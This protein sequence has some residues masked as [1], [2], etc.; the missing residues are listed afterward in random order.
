[1]KTL[2]SKSK[3]AGEKSSSDFYYKDFC[4][5][6]GSKNLEPYLDL[7]E[8]PLVNNYGNDKKYELKV[9][10]CKDCYFSQLGIV[11]DPD[12]LFSHYYFQSSVSKLMSKHFEDLAYKLKDRF[13]LDKSSFCVDVASNDGI[14]LRAWKKIGVMFLGVDPAKN[15]AERANREGLDT[16]AEYWQNVNLGKK[17]DVITAANVFA[18]TDDVDG[19]LKSTSKNLKD[20]GVFVLEFPHGQE[21]ILKREFDTIYHEHLSYILLNPLV[22]LLE[23]Y[24]LQVIDVEKLDVH[25]GSLRVYVAKSNSKYEVTDWVKKILEEEKR[26][27]LLDINNYYRFAQE[28]ENKRK[29]LIGTISKIKKEGLIVGYA[30]SAKGNVLINYCGFSSKDIKYIIDDNEDKQ[31]NLIPGTD[32]P[33]V[34][35]SLLDKDKPKYLFILSPNIKEDIINKTHDFKKSGGRYIWAMPDIETI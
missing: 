29:E 7:G 17:A 28:V 35:R 13:D 25:G 19:F 10:L 16:I 15:L 31:G 11:V 18:H 23:K 26:N 30:A 14:M 4:R 32:I 3:E 24:N 9:N 6:C 12:I 1:M 20:D 34:A 8:L 33:V 22:R 2:Q 27:G 21:F 5:A